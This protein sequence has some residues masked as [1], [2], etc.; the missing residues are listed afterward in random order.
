MSQHLA[1]GAGTV[2]GGDGGNSVEV[3]KDLWNVLECMHDGGMDLATFLERIM[4]SKSTR[5]KQRL[6]YFY[7]KNGFGRTFDAMLP[8]MDFS[9]GKRNFTT[10]VVELKQVLGKGIWEL[11][12]QVLELEV[13]SYCRDSGTRM[14]VQG[15]SPETADGFN[16]ETIYNKIEEHCPRLLRIVT[17]ISC[18]QGPESR[19]RKK[20]KLRRKCL[21]GE[22]PTLSGLVR[23]EGIEAG[24]AET[25]GGAL[26]EDEVSGQKRKHTGSGMA[27]DHGMEKRGRIVKDKRLTVTTSI[28][29][30][31]FAR[32]KM[33]NLMQTPLGYYLEASG[34]GK[35]VIGFLNR[36]GLSV[37]YST[38]VR[39]MKA[40]GD[41]NLE[42]IR[43]R[44]NDVCGLELNCQ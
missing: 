1:K 24:S 31:L 33:S 40:M 39:S 43:E 37:S 5:I 29:A 6:G 12:Q 44:I 19:A 3:D 28:S 21:G 17:G 32:S 20:R 41:A 14:G 30:M 38:I 42:R 9:P 13:K 36:C 7:K 18:G 2:G 22:D 16:F 8:Y 4:S 35:D 15:M 27:R 10:S 26:A 34:V 23:E 11:V 25:I